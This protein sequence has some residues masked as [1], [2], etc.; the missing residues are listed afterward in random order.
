VTVTQG[1][2]QQ[3]REVEGGKGTMSQNSLVQHFGFGHA[4]TPVTVEVEFGPRSRVVLKN[5]KP[6]Q[7]ITVEEKP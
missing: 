5:V 6:D 1:E 7:L 4:D 3:I 2:Q